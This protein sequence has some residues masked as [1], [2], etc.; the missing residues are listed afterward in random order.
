MR[1]STGK[2]GV[3]RTPCSAWS[4]RRNRLEHLGMP[5]IVACN[6]FVVPG[7]PL[8]K[9][10]EAL[11]LCDDVPLIDCDARDRESSKSVLI[12]LVDYLYGLSTGESTR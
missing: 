1:P 7:H 9:L 10:R 3:R 8:G 12:A 5:F 11:D 6:R 2:K 4:S